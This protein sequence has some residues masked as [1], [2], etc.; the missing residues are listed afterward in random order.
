MNLVDIKKRNFIPSNSGCYR[1]NPLNRNLALEIQE[2]A[3]KKMRVVHRSFIASCNSTLTLATLTC[4]LVALTFR[5][6]RPTE[7]ILEDPLDLWV[8]THTHFHCA[9]L[10]LLVDVDR[11]A[12]VVVSG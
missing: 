2:E 3:S 12:F 7:I 4:A 6:S 1:S 5:C 11:I 9:S 8:R 10:I